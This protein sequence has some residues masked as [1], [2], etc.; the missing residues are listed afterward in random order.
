[1]NRQER[2]KPARLP[3]EVFVRIHASGVQRD[4]AETRDISAKGLY[5]H[6]RAR[7]SPGQELEC[8]LV[9]PEELTHAPAPMLVECRGKVLRVNEQLPG[10]TVG[11]ALEIYSHDFS[12]P[13]DPANRS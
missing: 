5:L 8:V 10:Q 4:L 7:L 9:L 11:A 2:R 12:W 13:I 1:M 6:T 3:L